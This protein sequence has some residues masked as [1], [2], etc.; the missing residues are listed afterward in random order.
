MAIHLHT[1]ASHPDIEFQV[2]LNVDSGPGSG[3]P[4]YNEDW[5]SDVPKLNA[6][7]NVHTFGY[8]PLLYGTRA[9]LHVV[10]DVKDWANWNT[11]TEANISVNG[12]FFDSV[13]N[14]TQK[15]KQKKD[16]ATMQYFT[17][18]AQESFESVPLFDIIFNPG[19][20]VVDGLS[21]EYFELADQIVVY[22]QFA[23]NYTADA[24]LANDYMPEGMEDRL[25]I[26]LH[27]FVESGLPDDTVGEWL[28]T[29]MEAGL[30]STNILNY[31][32]EQCNSTETPASL[33]GVA[34]TLVAMDEGSPS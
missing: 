30:G 25:I 21:P 1:I 2:I 7:S 4:G 14:D 16:L 3:T 11:Y 20:R 27:D 9:T 34:R 29:F 6:F 26:L 23:T 33:D 32:Y 8:V 19:T 10:Q 13:P 18:L 22:E 24:P 31:G 17:R 5:L 12:I 28:G 15:K